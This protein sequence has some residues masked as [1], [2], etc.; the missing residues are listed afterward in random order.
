MKAL[1][2]RETKFISTIQA[3]QRAISKW[4]GSYRPPLSGYV[5][6]I[7]SSKFPYPDGWFQSMFESKFKA[8]EDLHSIEIRLRVPAKE[9]FQEIKMTVGGEV[10]SLRQTSLAQ[11]HQIDIPASIEKGKEF[12]LS[13]EGEMSASMSDLGLSEDKRPLSFM[14]ISMLFIKK[15]EKKKGSNSGS[16]IS[17]KSL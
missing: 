4:E 16:K 15:D 2:E 14:L 11:T 7:E 8:L 13:L 5:Q 12:S 6:Q 3:L 1:Y 10:H 9:F 17:S